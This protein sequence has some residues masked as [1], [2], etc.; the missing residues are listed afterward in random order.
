MFHFAIVD[1]VVDHRAST[2][3]AMLKRPSGSEKEIELK[4]NG[5]DKN[6]NVNIHRVTL[7]KNQKK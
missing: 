2:S 5:Y 6:L 3:T 7:T 4:I 1:F